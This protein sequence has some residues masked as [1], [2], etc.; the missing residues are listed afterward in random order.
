MAQ[1]VGRDDIE[2]LRMELAELGRSM[3]SSA[4]GSRGS[5]LRRNHSNLS[6]SNGTIGAGGHELEDDEIQLQWAAI[7]RLPTMQRLRS[8][9]IFDAGAA[10]KVDDGKGKPQ[11][12]DVTRLGDE[13]RHTFID[14]LIQHIENDNR[15]LLHKM[16][17]RVDKY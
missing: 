7:E 12:M 5:S 4:M 13:Q 6:S 2:S 3:R 17:Q 14:K 9:L 8:S 15:R 10:T 16:R 11:V 1:L